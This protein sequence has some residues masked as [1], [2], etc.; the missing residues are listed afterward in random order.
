MKIL[1]ISIVCPYPL[2]AGGSIAYFKSLNQMRAIHE[3]TLVCPEPKESDRK[4]LETLWPDVNFSFFHIGDGEHQDTFLRKV[5]NVFKA[6][7]TQNKSEEF[8]SQ[9]QLNRLD[10]VNYYFNDLVEIVQKKCKEN[11]FD[12]AIVDF[13]DLIS[14]VHFLPKNIKKLFVHH[15]IKYQR[16]QAEYTSIGE[17]NIADQWF[18]NNIKAL[19]VYH[20]NAYDRVLALSDLDKNRLEEAGV[21][22]EKIRVSPAAVEIND[23]DINKPFVFKNK[24]AFLGPDNHFPNLD[25]VDW[26]LENIWPKIY[27]NHPEIQFNIIGK[28]TEHNKKRYFEVPNV[29]FKGFVKNLEDELNGAIMLVPLR[30]G[31]GMRMKILEGAAYHCPIVATYTGAEG[32][33]VI[34][35]THCLLAETIEE[36]TQKCNSLIQN[37]ALQ[38]ELIIHSQALFENRYSEEQ[39]GKIREE[40]LHDC[41]K[42]S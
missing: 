15:E 35:G 9:M 12:T 21:K 32:L 37:T 8:R 5:V 3:V 22:S 39:V 38:N 2:D 36:F 4:K 25:G 29:V 41:L 19:E 1:A 31:G 34:E 24:L 42:S 7:K 17:D 10:F 23:H 18:I 33:P 6:K 20:M 27:Q 14:I 13:I 28:W 40:I 26:F 11:Q 30:I 16:L